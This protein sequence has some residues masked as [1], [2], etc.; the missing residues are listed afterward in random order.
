MRRIFLGPVEIA[1]YYHNLAQG[2]KEL[3][4]PCDHICY[5]KNKN[6]YKQEEVGGIILPLIRRL[7]QNQ[8]PFQKIIVAIFIEFLAAI[9]FLKAIF[10]YDVFI[11]GF[12][13][14]LLPRTNLD[15]LLLKKLNKKVI[16]V[17]A[18]G[19]EARPPYLMVRT[20]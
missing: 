14:S 17:L 1:G 2:F 12:G 4:I 5:F 7:N 8:K 19:S 15:L 6:D 11:F 10:K 9:F 16:F 13:C 20:K 3:G 18:H